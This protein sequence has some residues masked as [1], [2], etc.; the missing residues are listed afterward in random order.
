MNPREQ[1]IA[2]MKGRTFK[3]PEAGS[4]DKSVLDVVKPVAGPDEPL[5]VVYALP[6]QRSLH[7]SELVVFLQSI[8]VSSEG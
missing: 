2:G 4:V 6:P 5:V 1:L 3:S 8:S 7:E